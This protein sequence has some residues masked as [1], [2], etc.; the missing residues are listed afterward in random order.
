[1]LKLR[2]SNVIWGFLF[3]VFVAVYVMAVSFRYLPSPTELVGDTGAD[4]WL[5]FATVLLAVFAFWQGWISRDTARR[6]LRAYVCIYGGSIILRQAAQQIFL[7]GYVTLKNFGD[8]PAY[9]HSCWI[10]IDLRDANDPP[11]AVLGNGLTKAIL[12][13]DGE[14]SC[15][16]ITGLFLL[17]T[18]QIFA[19]KLKG[20]SFGAEPSTQ[21][22]LARK[23]FTS[24]IVGTPRNCPARDGR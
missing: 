3:G 1:M 2:I 23:G 15:L 16:C 8:T 6:Q 14:A 17:K 19:M 12:S 7:E 21:T 24:G 5:V 13:P 22:H 18:S 20:F 9:D 10:R 4:R 11:F